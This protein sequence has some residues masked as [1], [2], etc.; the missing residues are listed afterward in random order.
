MASLKRKRAQ[1]D[2]PDDEKYP[3]L[4][5]KLADSETPLRE[6]RHLL[7]SFSRLV[8]RLPVPDDGSPVVWD[9]TG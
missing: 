3:G 2:W 6:K 5:I 7:A 9:L 4:L 1:D 8:K